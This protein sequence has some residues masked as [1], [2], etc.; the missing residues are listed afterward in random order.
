MARVGC[1]GG[2]GDE[3]APSAGRRWRRRGGRGGSWIRG[4]A[5]GPSAEAGE[6][7][8]GRGEGLGV[9]RGGRPEPPGR[10]RRAG[11]GDKIWNLDSG[12]GLQSLQRRRKR[13]RGGGE[14][15]EWLGAAARKEGA[16]RGS[17]NGGDGG[18][19]ARYARSH[20]VA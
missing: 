12:M 18:G 15:E 6:G 3:K 4:D 1:S 5:K 8:Q 9:R 10:R 16:G 2:F 19:A 7:R 11:G 20:L 14:W 13:R 17:G